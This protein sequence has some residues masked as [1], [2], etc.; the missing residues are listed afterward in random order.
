VTAYPVRYHPIDGEFSGAWHADYSADQP[1]YVAATMA[2]PTT[3]NPIRSGYSVDGGHTWTQFATRPLN[4]T[5]S[6][7]VFGFGSIHVGQPGHIIWV[8][9]L[10]KGTYR[11]TDHGATWTAVTIPGVT[12]A[13]LN[14]QAWFYYRRPIASEKTAGSADT[15]YAHVPSSGVYRSTDAG[16]T[17]TQR[18]DFTQFGATNWTQHAYLKTVPDHP[19]HLFLSPGYQG[20]PANPALGTPFKRSTDGGVTWSTLTSI[21]TVRGFDFGIGAAGSSYPAIYAIGRVGTTVGVYRSDDN[22]ATWTLLSTQPHNTVDTIRN[23]AASKEVYG[24]HWLTVG[25]SGLIVGRLA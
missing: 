14:T 19:G 16:A 5:N 24:T 13:N 8:G 7:T 21:D 12:M 23:V 11:T 3:F 9:A 25:G 1:A 20:T 4:S 6:Q 22:A 15:F 18:C 17:W 10:S 2:P